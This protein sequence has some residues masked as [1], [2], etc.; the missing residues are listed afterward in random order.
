V[1][2]QQS[3]ALPY[4]VFVFWFC[5]LRLLACVLSLVGSGQTL[6]LSFSLAALC[7]H[8]VDAFGSTSGE[9]DRRRKGMGLEGRRRVKWRKGGSG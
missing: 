1:I 5:I 6:S 8:S 9:R 7:I 3:L 4:V 2:L